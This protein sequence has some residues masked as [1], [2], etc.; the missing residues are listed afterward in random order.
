[1]PLHNPLRV[2]EEWSIVD[3]LSRGRVGIS[4]VSGW[5]PNDFAFFPERY[6]NK[7][8]EMFRGIV[9]VQKLWRGEKITTRDG[10]GKMAEIGVFPQPIQS[11]LPIWL[12]CSR[13][14][15]MFVKAGELG[16]NVLTSLQ[17]QSIDEVTAHLKAY[18]EARAQAGHDP[19]AG[20]VAMMMHTFVGQS[21]D[22]V[23]EKV[24]EPL[25]SFLRSHLD[26]IKT[27]T[28][29]LDIEAGL[30]K[31][32]LVDSIV[33][34]AFERYYRTA[35]L[36]GAPQTCLPMIERLKSIGVNE[37]ACLIDFGVDVEST[38]EGLVHLNTLKQLCQTIPTTD[39]KA[40]PESELASFLQ[41]K[42]PSSLVPKSLIVVNNLPKPGEEPLQV[43]A[44]SQR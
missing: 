35:S 2:A 3:N 4:F 34:F 42:L 39:G 6:A 28:N 13:G 44:M 15:E 10:A 20:Q 38:L 31:P 18:R 30:E 33:A 1:M 8:D 25:S 12:T 23:V 19:Y 16:F 14:V 22:K 37:V 5:V 9:E 7:R 29:S 40:T 24:R 43:Q 32:E 21:K 41:Q 26:L 17:A 11:E 27:F 36:I